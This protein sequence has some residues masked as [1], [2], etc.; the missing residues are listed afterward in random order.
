MLSW[1]GSHLSNA[2]LLVMMR[3]VTVKSG[4]DYKLF[5]TIFGAGMFFDQAIEQ[6]NCLRAV[7]PAEYIPNL[8]FPILFMNGELDH[9]DSEDRWLELC[10][11]DKSE[12]K[13]YPKPG[14]HFFTHF[15]QFV[16]DI[17]TRWH[18]FAEKL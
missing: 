3:D 16:D 11:N 18:D 12:L 10:T 1:L 2:S 5:E 7:A 6:V 14:D 8:D 17:L 15:S 13:D 4:A 9:R